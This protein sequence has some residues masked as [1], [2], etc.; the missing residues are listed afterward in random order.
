MAF[1]Y[2]LDNPDHYTNQNFV[3]FYWK[4]Y[5]TGIKSWKQN[6]DVHP[7]KVILLKMRMNLLDFNSGLTYT[8][9][10][11]WVTSPCMNR[12]K[13]ITVKMH[14]NRTEKI[15]ESKTRFEVTGCLSI[16]WRHW[17]GFWKWFKPW[18]AYIKCNLLFWLLVND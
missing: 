4:S 10:M 1:L 11:N 16:Q 7:D 17:Y 6:S 12:L 13:F 8:D 9:H 5:I 2:L 14:Q 3:L 18:F 15:S